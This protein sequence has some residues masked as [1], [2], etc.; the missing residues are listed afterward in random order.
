MCTRVYV[1]G[2]KIV[3]ATRNA[4]CGAK[5]EMCALYYGI[6]LPSWIGSDTVLSVDFHGVR[7]V[8]PGYVIKIP[9]TK[10]T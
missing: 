6:G 2:S 9:F 10:I 5:Y 7:R 3:L 1:A 4:L 8:V